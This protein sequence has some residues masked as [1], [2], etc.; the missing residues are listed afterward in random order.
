MHGHT[1]SI[2]DAR[3]PINYTK[4]IGYNV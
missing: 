2:T 4:M 3:K 1:P